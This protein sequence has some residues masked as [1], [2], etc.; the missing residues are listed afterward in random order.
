[1]AAQFPLAVVLSAVDRITSPLRQVT[2]GVNAFGQRWSVLGSEIS[3]ALAPLLGLGG[4]VLRT[5]L[6]SEASFKRVQAAT[7]AS[8][9]EMRALAD[10]VRAQADQLGQRRLLGALQGL[11]DEGF[12]VADALSALPSTAKLAKLALMDGAQ[13]ASIVDDVLKA[14]GGDVAALSARLDQMVSVAGGSRVEL[15]KLTSALVGNTSAAEQAGM[16]FEDQVAVI[17]ALADR[18]IEAGSAAKALTKILGELQQ[19][20]KTAG[21]VLA[22]LGVDRSDVFDA[23]NRLRSLGDVLELLRR[24]GATTAEFMTIFGDRTGQVLASL[25]TAA[26]DRA[27]AAIADSAGTVDNRVAEMSQGAGEAFERLRNSLDQLRQSLSESGF[28]DAVAAVIDGLR[29]VVDW[30][31]ALPPGFRGVFIA[32]QAI[33]PVFGG[34]ALLARSLRGFFGQLLERLLGL[35]QYLKGALQP[36]WEHLSTTLLSTPISQLV[37]WIDML[38]GSGRQLAIS[39]RTVVAA[40]AKGWELWTNPVRTFFSWLALTIANLT[41]IVPDWMRDLAK[42]P[43]L[44]GGLAGAASAPAASSVREVLSSAGSASTVRNEAHVK[45]EFDNLPR[46]TTVTSGKNSGLNLDL[47]LGYAMGS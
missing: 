31:R 16:S 38:I 1:M 36:L 21:S 35:G 25:D 14:T 7:G 8:A 47:G 40:L 22:R 32:L 34:L 17:K 9:L 11:A 13:A 20:S 37:S 15:E 46:G 28:L 27:R 6:D 29:S 3:G 33:S 23:T 45:V 42:S 2:Q 44:S 24:K 43:L 4:L 19:P 26:I 12:S 39:W 5:G 41:D 10:A 18:G 30:V